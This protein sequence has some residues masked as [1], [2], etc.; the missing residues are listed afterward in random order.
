MPVRFTVFLLSFALLLVVLLKTV[1]MANVKEVSE[2]LRVIISLAAKTLVLSAFTTCSS[3][4]FLHHLHPSQLALPR[5]ICLILHGYFL[6]LLGVLGVWL[7]T[8]YRRGFHGPM[9]TSLFRFKQIIRKY[10]WIYWPEAQ[11][12]E[13][14]TYILNCS[15]FPYGWLNKYPNY[16]RPG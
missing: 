4:C 15:F 1:S 10:I 3:W 7:T 2:K 11:G 8:S 5:N 16:T 13:A 6:R 14:I 12:F 9:G